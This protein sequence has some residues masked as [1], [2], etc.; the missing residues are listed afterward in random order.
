MMV[1]PKATTANDAQM[2]AGMPNGASLVGSIRI[3]SR[4]LRPSP[5]QIK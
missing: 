1:M 4:P 2:F 3:A 5:Y